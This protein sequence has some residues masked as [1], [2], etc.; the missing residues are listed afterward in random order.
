MNGLPH[1]CGQ[2]HAERRANHVSIEPKALISF[3]YPY[4]GDFVSAAC[5]NRVYSAVK[6][7]NGMQISSVAVA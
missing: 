1:A 5:D 2:W 3:V 6:Y 7:D 4:V